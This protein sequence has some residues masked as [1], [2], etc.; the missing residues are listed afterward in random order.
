MVTHKTI[1]Y[2][3]L[4]GGIICTFHYVLCQMREPRNHDSL[5][6]IDTLTEQF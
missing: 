4:Y 1:L 3:Y 6:V 2:G 5:V